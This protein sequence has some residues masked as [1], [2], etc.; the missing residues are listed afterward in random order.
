MPVRQN[1]ASVQVSDMRRLP[2]AVIVLLVCPLPSLAQAPDRSLERVALALQNSPVTIT[3]D[4]W[5]TAQPLKLGP[6][7]QVPPVKR[8]E[9]IRLSLPVGEYVTKAAKSVSAAN[10][11]RQEARAKREVAAALQEFAERTRK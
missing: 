2:A 9:M 1:A 6:F 7:T 3:T 8:G 4:P 11:R 5:M 10:R